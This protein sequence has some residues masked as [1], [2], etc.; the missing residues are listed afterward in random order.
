LKKKT[1]E[2]ISKRKKEE[3]DI[4][5]VEEREKDQKYLEKEQ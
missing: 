5:T 2:E 1:K 4:I 3:V